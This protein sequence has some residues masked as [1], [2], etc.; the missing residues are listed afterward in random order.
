M[1]DSL[2]DGCVRTVIGS[3]RLL[4]IACLL[5]PKSVAEYILYRACDGAAV[6]AVQV[7]TRCWPHSDLSFDFMSNGYC[8]RHKQL[9]MSCISAESYYNV[10]SSDE[11]AACIPSIV[12]GLFNNLYARLEECDT[13]TLRS[14]DLSKIRISHSAHGELI[15]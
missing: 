8:R 3:V 9:S 14:V 1:D 7:L 4:R 13:P 6:A 5:L 15:I 2:F 12:L 10:L 11:Y